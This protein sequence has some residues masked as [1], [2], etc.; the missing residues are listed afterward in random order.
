VPTLPTGDVTDGGGAS[1]VTG[2]Y[3]QHVV[4][5]LEAGGVACTE[6]G[7]GCTS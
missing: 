5:M 6:V 3:A 2:P 4:S 7:L 1:V